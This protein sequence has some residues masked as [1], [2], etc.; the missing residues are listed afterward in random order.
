MLGCILF[1]FG[2]K[3]HI[4]FDLMQ[5]MCPIQAFKTHVFLQMKITHK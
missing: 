2:L 4:N 1:I 5:I 3:E